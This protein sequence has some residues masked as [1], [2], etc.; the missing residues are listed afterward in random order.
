MAQD[1][2]DSGS[3]STDPHNTWDEKDSNA[4]DLTAAQLDLPRN[5]T[6]STRRGTNPT[7]NLSGS[8]SRSPDKSIIDDAE[9]YQGEKPK[10]RTI[11][12]IL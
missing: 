1:V 4:P 7:P 3:Q 8:A 6:R 5:N 2:R 12:G 11:P 10:L 9:R